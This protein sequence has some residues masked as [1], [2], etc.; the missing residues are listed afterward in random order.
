MEL[1][2]AMEDRFYSAEQGEEFIEKKI[3]TIA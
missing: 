1:T 3:L 2:Q